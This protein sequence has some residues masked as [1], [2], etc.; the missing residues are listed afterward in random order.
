MKRFAGR[1]AA[2][3]VAFWQYD[4][5]YRRAWFVWPQATAILLA[6]WLLADRAALPVGKWA[7]PA[8]C[9]NASNPGCAAT[10]RVML[11]WVDEVSRPT[12][13]NQATVTVDRSAFRSSAAADQPKLSAALGAYYRREWARAVDI[14]KS[15]TSAD[16]NVQYVT[17]LALLIPGTTDQVRDAQT[18]LRTAAAAGHRQA[19]GML[20]RTLIVGSGG[21]PKDEAQGRRL[22][23][24]GAAAGDTYA[25]R[26]AAAGYLNREFSGAYDSVKAVD[27]VRK[28]ADAGEPVAMAQLAYFIRTGRGGI[29]RDDSKVLDYL[30]RSAEAGY[31]EAQFTLGRWATDRYEKRE[32]EDPSEGIK[33]YE[34]AYQRSYSSSSLVNLARAHRY[35]RAMPWFDTKR[36]FELLQLCAPYAYSFCHYWLARAY[37]DGAGTPQD[38]VKAHAHY[39]IARQLGMQEASTSLQQLD[40]RLLPAAKSTATHLAESIS[41]NL[42][43]VPSVIMLQSPEAESAAP[44]PWA[45]PQS[46]QPPQPAAGPSAPSQQSSA[47]WTTCKGNDIDPAIAACTRLITSGIT[48][49]DLGL[50]YYFQG[51]NYN[52]KKQY[53]QAI[54]EYDKAIQLR[55]NL[56]SAHNNRGIAYKGL[57]NLEAALRDYD[58]A[59]QIDPS[60]A[61]GY[62]NRAYA[63][64]LRNQLDEA[65]TDATASIRLNGKRARSYWIRAGA[66]EEKQQWTEVVADCTTA[67][68][69]D[70]KYSDCFDRRG[71]ASYRLDKND[72]ALADFNESLRLHPQSSWTLMMRGNVRKE[73]QLF[74]VA[75]ADYEE[76]IRQDPKNDLAY[77]NRA[78]AYYSKKQYALAV[79]DATKSIEINSRRAFA[80]GVRGFALYELERFDEA[81]T[82]LAS[83]TQLNPKW[84][85]PRY[86][87][88]VAEARIEEKAYESC[89][90]PGNRQPDANRTVGGLPVCMKGLEFATSLKELAEVIRLDPQYASAYAYR[91]YL[92]VKLQQRERGIAELRKAL[93]IDQN[94][95]FARDT[96]RS[97]NVAP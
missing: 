67:I 3:H 84:V 52:E 74:D 20:G 22:I 60:Y 90:K 24:D 32:T 41:A 75:I 28:A 79:A 34:R 26:L 39:S 73:Q 4:P 45:A 81:S 2:L 15:S 56:A 76:A 86:W 96:L 94:H 17:A 43:P 49:T 47:D 1:T 48:G 92:Y 72:L 89:P 7:K 51:W 44:S 85:K 40:G 5:W 31:L 27:L 82:D 29:A 64:L 66:Y 8:D 77:A 97:I 87:Y 53:Q 57:G 50:A 69:L 33:W 9:S 71:Y 13:A 55:A 70:P 6:G 14:L 83:A 12:I 63:H 37:H 38:V 10:Q 54:A 80:F 88:A 21:L 36:S 93:Q 19:G 25:M 95:V 68:G 35:A 42:K 30:R 16:P 91:G 59:V 58:E 78:D 62:E 11:S 18:L 46:P 61:L 65:M 23:E